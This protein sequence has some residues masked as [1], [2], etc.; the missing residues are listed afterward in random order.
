MGKPPTF[1]KGEWIV[2]NSSSSSRTRAETK[3]IGWI[4]GFIERVTQQCK[5]WP[6]HKG[7]RKGERRNPETIRNT[8]D[9]QSLHNTSRWN[10]C[11]GQQWQCSAMES[12]TPDFL[13]WAYTSPSHSFG[14]CPPSS[15][16]LQPL[17]HISPPYIL[18]AVTYHTFA[19]SQQ[20]PWFR[21]IPLLPT[22]FSR[23]TTKECWQPR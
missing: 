8:A 23:S 21:N 12:V 4:P 5:L 1:E 7:E 2:R 19:L 18:T 16:E 22:Q 15:P 6:N 11:E 10:G 14:L 20:W 3:S 13:D 17:S 9:W